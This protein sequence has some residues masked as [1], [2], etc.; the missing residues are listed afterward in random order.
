MICSVF[1]LIK[2]T[3]N[4]SILVCINTI[5]N[6]NEK[7]NN[8]FFL[9]EYCDFFH[10]MGDRDNTMLFWSTKTGFCEYKLNITKKKL[11]KFFLNFDYLLPVIK[12]LFSGTISN[13]KLKI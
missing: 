7:C 1:Y 6:N 3:N 12:L 5:N 10:D 11:C 4:N 13:E 8:K 9:L 2:L